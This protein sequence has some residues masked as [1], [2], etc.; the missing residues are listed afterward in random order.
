MSE[1]DALDTIARE[2]MSSIFL[3]DT[4][5]FHERP[6][7]MDAIEAHVRAAI[8]KTSTTVHLTTNAPKAPRP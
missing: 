2:C 4:D 6:T 7:L 8:W 3:E 5:H 1:H